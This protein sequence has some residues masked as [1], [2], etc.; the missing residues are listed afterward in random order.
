MWGCSSIFF[1]QN[2]VIDLK[3]KSLQEYGDIISS[4]DDDIEY[5]SLHV[6]ISNSY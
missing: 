2:N 6:K 1:V 3:Y 4:T 5:F